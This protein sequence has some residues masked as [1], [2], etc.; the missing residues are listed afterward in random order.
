MKATDLRSVR[1]AALALAAA[2]MLPAVALAEQGPRY[3]YLGLSYE[4]TDVKYA[5]REQD[6][7][8]DGFKI[9]GSVA[10]S[11]WL[12]LFGEYSDGDFS[13]SVETEVEPG[14]FVTTRHDLDFS[15]Y[16]VGLG[17]S[18]P[19]NGT[20]DIVGRAAYV[21][22]ELDNIDD[23]GFM[24]EGLIRAMIS[25]RAEIEVGYRYT[26]LR[27][28][29]I[30]NRDLSVALTYNITDMFAVRARGIIFDNDTG[31]ELGVRVYFGD[32]LTKLF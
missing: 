19:L 3:T 24:V 8:H 5:V 28:S 21:Y 2:A 30:D 27:D 7:S 25:E 12:H 15:G 11:N 17:V 6:Q 32:D 22:A 1:N 4:W 23:D 16:Q 26:E 13:Q 14:E 9:E 31:I 18:Y 29:D 20:V 10:L